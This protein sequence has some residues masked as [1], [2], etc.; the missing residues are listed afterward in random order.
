MS[1]IRRATA[2]WKAAMAAAA[3]AGSLALAACSGPASAL[4]PASGGR[5]PGLTGA[6]AAP[7]PASI[8]SPPPMSGMAGMPSASPAGA[9]AA[10]PVATNTVT[11]QN[12]AFSPEV[13]TVKAGTT[14]RWTNR[15]TDDHTVTSDTS[16]FGSAALA[17]GASYAH[18]FTTPGTYKYHC[19]IHPFMVATV[20][21]TA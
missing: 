4:T 3:V 18:T 9:A 17:T 21:V 13:V 10:A 19:S 20:V 7:P 1:S 11:I 8:P 12:F 14:V 6:T 16:A 5:L 15:D 2:R